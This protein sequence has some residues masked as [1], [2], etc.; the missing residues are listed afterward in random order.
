MMNNV[1]SGYCVA[2]RSA[3]QPQPA[4]KALYLRRDPL[5]KDVPP[6]LYRPWPGQV[7]DDTTAAPSNESIY[8]QTQWLPQCLSSLKSAFA[9]KYL[10]FKL[11]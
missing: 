6:V 9:Y 3:L 10:T 11:I 8:T 4:I 1:V 2:T 7:V 5:L